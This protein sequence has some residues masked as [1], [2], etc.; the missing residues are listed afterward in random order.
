MKKLAS[1]LFVS[2]ALTACGSSNDSAKSNKT[3][4]TSTTTTTPTT[5][6]A[7][8]VHGI[9]P[10]DV[11]NY[12]ENFQAQYRQLSLQL[13]GVETEFSFVDSDEESKVLILRIK[14]GLLLA[15]FDPDKEEP[16]ASLTW[17]ESNDSDLQTVFSNPDKTYNGQNIELEESGD[18]VVYSGS[19]VDSASQRSVSV[20]LV[21]NES[22]MSAGSSKIEVND[23]QAIITGDL[24]TNFYIQLKELIAQ[25]P[26]VTTLVLKNVQGSVNDDINM[27]SGR[28]VRNAQLTTLMP[29]DGEA[30]SGGVDLFASGFK[31]VYQQGGKLGVHSWCC[32]DGKGAGELGRE[33]KAHGAQLTFFREMLGTDLGPEFYFFTIEAAPHDDIHLMTQAEIDKYLLVGQN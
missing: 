4:T 5:S 30:H 20:R 22:L 14:Q 23:T 1:V 29:A 19:L 11:D 8:E 6:T 15:G 10:A 2:L 32:E 25:Q 24:G 33:H 9:K 27:H 12:V 17:L 3:E 16:L 13:D 31:R 7:T 21:I 28:L 26:K 18:N